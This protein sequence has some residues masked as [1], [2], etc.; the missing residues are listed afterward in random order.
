MTIKAWAVIN[1]DLQGNPF[2]TPPLSTRLEDFYALSIFETKKEALRFKNYGKNKGD[3]VK[4]V[5]I[6]IID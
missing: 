3:K 2:Y 1:E 5:E 4:K 6:K